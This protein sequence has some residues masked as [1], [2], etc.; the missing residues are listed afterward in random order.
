MKGFL[1]VI[2]AAAQVGLI[3]A[4]LAHVGMFVGIDA[5]EAWAWTLGVLLI[6][7]IVTGLCGIWA[8]QEPGKDYS[9][10]NRFWR[11]VLLPACPIWMRVVFYVLIAYTVL[12][13]VLTVALLA[14]TGGDSERTFGLTFSAGFASLYFASIMLLWFRLVAADKLP[15]PLPPD[16]DS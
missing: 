12:L 6:G 14:I 1:R 11:E 16:G 2:L 4:A 10:D 15:P 3:A 13:L 9:D 7:C 5:P 8:I